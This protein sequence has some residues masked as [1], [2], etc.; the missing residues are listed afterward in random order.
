V[1]EIE[2][3]NFGG[4][5]SIDAPFLAPEENPARSDSYVNQAGVAGID[6]H[7]AP[8]TDRA[9]VY[10]PQD[11]VLIQRSFDYERPR[12]EEAR[13]SSSGST[14][15][16]DYDVGLREG[17]YLNFD[18]PFGAGVYRVYLRQ[19]VL[20]LDQSEAVLERITRT[21]EGAESVQ[22]LGHFYAPRSG[23]EFRNVPLTDENRRK[24]NLQFG[25]R[26]NLRLRQV[27]PVPS[28]AEI[29]LNY[30]VFQNSVSSCVYV[31]EASEVNGPY[32]PAPGVAMQNGRIS[33]WRP[34]EPARFYEV[35]GGSTSKLR[36]PRLSDGDLTFDVQ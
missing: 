6:F 20:N 16:Y 7:V 29:A 15:I 36:K 1:I 24:L 18:R 35:L 25:G 4:G 32:H 17:D 5:R 27:T 30:L 21:P 31:S 33:I 23:F 3:Y 34:D 19:A 12:Y 28:D 14:N 26:E 8:L 9:P 10:R 11:P 22:V 13:A 2:D